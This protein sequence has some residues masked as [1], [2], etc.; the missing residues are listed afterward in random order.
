MMIIPNLKILFMVVGIISLVVSSI[1]FINYWDSG[2]DAPTFV[3]VW[4]GVALISIFLA[5]AIPGKREMAMIV[6][7]GITYNV[8]TSE[9]AKQLGGKALQLLNNK[10]DELIDDSKEEKSK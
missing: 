5:S 3:K 7:G 8:V 9:P 4:F 6:A 2:D 1:M 10:L